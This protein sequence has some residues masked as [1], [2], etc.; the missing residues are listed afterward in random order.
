MQKFFSARDRFELNQN[1]NDFITL[2]AIDHVTELVDEN[3]YLRQQLEIFH[4]DLSKTTL[5]DIILSDLQKEWLRGSEI[6]KSMK[7]KRAEQKVS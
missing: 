2:S 3:K 4:S 7:H 1:P 5:V 6:V